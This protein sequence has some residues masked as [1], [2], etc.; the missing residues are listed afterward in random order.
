M[1][2]KSE[3]DTVIAI[4]D[5]LN[6][7]LGKFVRIMKTDGEIA[8]YKLWDVADS[9]AWLYPKYSRETVAI[10]VGHI[11]TVMILPER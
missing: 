1:H 10:H 7:N 3:V 11:A 5:T 2:D 8:D 6:H 4:I 9:C